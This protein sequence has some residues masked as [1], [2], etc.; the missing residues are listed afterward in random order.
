MQTHNLVVH[1]NDTMKEALSAINNGLKRIAIV[2]DSDNKLQGTINDGD[3]RRALL[4][5]K[6]LDTLV[7]DIYCKNPTV[8]KTTDSKDSIIKEAIKKKV[9]QIPIVDENNTFIKVEDLA[10][11]LSHE[12]RKNRVIL[13]AGGLGSRLKPLT[14]STPKPMLNVGNKPILETIIENFANYGFRD[15]TISVNYKADMIREHFKDGSEFGVNISYIQESERLGTAGALSLIKEKID[16]PFFVMNS[17]LLTNLNFEHLLDFHTDSKSMA[18]MC[19]REYDI[20]IPYGV[21]AT[22]NDKIKS[23]VEKPT[24]KFFVNAGIY[25]LDP[26]VLEYIPKGEFFDMPSLFE[27][28]IAKDY[29]TLSFPIHEYWLDIGKMIDYERANNEYFH[30]FE[31]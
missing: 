30:I 8:C 5:G 17:D 12:N 25:L 18:T 28:L 4:N 22:E 24:H 20:Q 19:V 27:K 9:Y 2:V 3:I 16:E 15:I 1:K 21:I 26:H 7:E 11:M 10:G 29:D 6:D 31:S 14:D 23:I 13:M